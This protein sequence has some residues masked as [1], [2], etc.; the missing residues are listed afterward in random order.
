MRENGVRFL[1]YLL[2]KN[3]VDNGYKYIINKINKLQN[4]YKI[5]KYKKDIDSKSTY[6]AIEFDLYQV[7]NE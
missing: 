5:N 2:I 3:K 4:G 7:I 6:D 1:E